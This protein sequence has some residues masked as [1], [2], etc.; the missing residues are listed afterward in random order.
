M[1]SRIAIVRGVPDTFCDALSMVHPLVPVDLEVARLQHETYVEVLAGLVKEV[2]RLPADNKYPDCPFIEDTAVVIGNRALITHPGATSRQGEEVVIR[3][4]LTQLGLDISEVECPGTIDGGDVLYASGML[5]V[6]KSRR[7]NAAGIEFLQKA[8][9]DV[10]VHIIRVLDGLHLKSVISEIAPQT[11]AVE[12]SVA[13][14]AMFDE[15]QEQTNGHFKIVK[16]DG[17]G[18]AN[19]VLVGDTVIC[20]ATLGLPADLEAH[21]KQHAKH[22]IP[23]NISEFHKV[24][25]GLT[26]LSLLIER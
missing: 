24:D 5:F 10:K 12:D 6:G 14:A 21:F 19:T 1:A 9:P 11:L 25:G 8:F 13:A 26:C 15:I 4:A 23:V 20:S 16:T 7:T 2:I 3:E 22:V 18:A 17:A